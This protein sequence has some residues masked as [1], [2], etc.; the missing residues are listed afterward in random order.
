LGCRV[1]HVSGFD[2]D[3][4]GTFTRNIPRAGIQ[5]EAARKK[6]CLGMELAGLSDETGTS[7]RRSIWGSCQ[8]TM[9]EICG[10]VQKVK[11]P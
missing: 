3:Q 2:T 10:K 6:A 8:Q 7:G 5:L 4:L 11:T 1:A 9:P